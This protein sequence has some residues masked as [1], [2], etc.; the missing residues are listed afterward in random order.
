VD[1]KN[2][3]GSNPLALAANNGHNSVVEQLL[4]TCKA[5]VDSKNNIGST[6]LVLAAYNG[7]NAAVELLLE[8]GKAVARDGRS[9]SQF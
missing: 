1:S 8:I 2:K 7:H 9:G 5:K 6:S 3:S 4:V